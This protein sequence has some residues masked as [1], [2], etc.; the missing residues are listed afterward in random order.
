MFSC[1]YCKILKNTY[2]EEHLRIAAPSLYSRYL[3][4]IFF[5]FNRNFE[6]KWSFD[7]FQNIRQKIVCAFLESILL[8]I[9]RTANFSYLF[10]LATASYFK[11]ADQRNLWFIEWSF[12]CMY[13]IF[14][15]KLIFLFSSRVGDGFEIYCWWKA[16]DISFRRWV[17]FFFYLYNIIFLYPLKN[18]WLKK[19]KKKKMLNKIKWNWNVWQFSRILGGNIWKNLG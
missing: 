12:L 8:K 9:V 16:I 15:V 17:W 5:S 10:L 1:E 13:S 19:K 14:L 2:S 6:W 11:F 4:E 3:S 18:K 7:L